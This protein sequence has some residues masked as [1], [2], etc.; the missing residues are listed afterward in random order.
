MYILCGVYNSIIMFTIG[1][2]DLYDLDTENKLQI[3]L[4]QEKVSG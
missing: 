3:L 1:M 2:N 4:W